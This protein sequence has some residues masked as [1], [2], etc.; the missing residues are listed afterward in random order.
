[1]DLG[2][3]IDLGDFFCC[4][5][6]PVFQLLGNGILTLP[7]L[8]D[9]DELPLVGGSSHRRTGQHPFGGQTEFCPNGFSGGGG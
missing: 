4:G 8:Y 5:V 9:V 1:M 6:D 7:T 3:P 2:E